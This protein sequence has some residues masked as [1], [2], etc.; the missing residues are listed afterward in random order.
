MANIKITEI[1]TPGCSH[2]AEA[3]RFLEQEVKPKYPN[4]EIEYVSVLDPRGQ[5]LVSRH[6]IFASPGILINDQLFATGGIN[7]KEFLRKVE[8]LSKS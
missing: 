2:C 3:H 5:E 7:K 1:S 8:E 6:M 4:V